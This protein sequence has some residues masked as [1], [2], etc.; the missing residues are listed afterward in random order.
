MYK[1]R[2]NTPERTCTRVY[3]VYRT[4][5]RFLVRDFNERCGYCDSPD[6]WCGGK[7]IFHIDH[8]APWKKFESTHP[9]IKTDYSN[10]I[11]SCPYCNGFKSDSW[12]SNDPLIAV[13]GD[14]GFIDPC[15]IIYDTL[16]NRND[17]GELI[18][19]NDLAE[20]MYRNLGLGLER[21]SLIWLLEKLST[22]IDELDKLV[23][24]PKVDRGIVKLI[25]KQKALVHDNFYRILKKFFETLRVK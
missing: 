12:V 15:D 21:H 22:Q 18:P 13:N 19:Q 9:S 17:L 11:Y 3:K 5:K 20:Y 6:V 16:F 7:R 25:K 14:E 4:Y 23:L 24:N 10:L 1:L 2:K 8:F